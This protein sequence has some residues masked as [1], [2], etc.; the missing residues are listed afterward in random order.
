[1]R[2][3]PYELL[4]LVASNLLPRYQCRL[5]LVSRHHYKHLYSDLLRWHAKW[6]L[7]TPPR[8]KY[9]RKTNYYYVSLM[10]FNKQLLLYKQTHSHG[11]FIYNLTR[12]YMT[13]PDH[14]LEHNYVINDTEIVVNTR[15]II[16]ICNALEN[17]NLLTGCYKYMHKELLIAYLNSKHP[18]LSMPSNIIEHI[19]NILP[20]PDKKSFVTSNV[21]LNDIYR[22]KLS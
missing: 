18:L 9:V 6:R 21:Y 7:V 14:N 8:Y 22:W 17:T 5:A 4:Q 11:L 16:H 12:M 15:G 19:I 10:E 13:P 1:M 2:S 20:G 3:L